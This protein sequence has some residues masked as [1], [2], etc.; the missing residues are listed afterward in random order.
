MS[1]TAVEP[2]PIKALSGDTPWQQTVKEPISIEGKGLFT[3]VSTRMI[4]HPA[5]P[6]H[7]VVF[8]SQGV[9]IAATIDYVTQTPRCTMLGKDGV[10]VICTEHLLSAL[11]ACR[12]DNV[13]IE[14]QG[15]EVPILDGSAR[16]FCEQLDSVGCLEQEVLA[17]VGSLHKSVVWYEGDVSLVALPSQQLQM[18]YVLQYAAHPLLALQVADWDGT[19]IAYQQQIAPNRTFSTQEELQPLIDQGLI[20]GGSVD[21]GVVFQRERVLNPEGLR[22]ANEPA[23]HKI[24]DLC[25]DISLLGCRLCCKIVA[26]RSGHRSNIA[27][28]QKLRGKLHYDSN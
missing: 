17:R 5:P 3:G 27:F 28:S 8:R 2:Q 22:F 14:V 20:R 26:V 23:R 24:L 11:F 4:L 15:P 12:V 13:L 1:K 9:D 19:H 25:G 21:V 16:P 10:Q 18:T 7:G 6:N